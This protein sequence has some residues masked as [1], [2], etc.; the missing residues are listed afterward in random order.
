MLSRSPPVSCFPTFQTIPDMVSLSRGNAILFP[1][2]TS[3]SLR[4]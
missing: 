3:H 1:K 4:T 2:A